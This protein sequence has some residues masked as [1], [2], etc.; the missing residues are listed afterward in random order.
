MAY[1]MSY[2]E[3]KNSKN[4]AFIVIKKIFYDE[5]LFL[6]AFCCFSVYKL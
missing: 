5:E 1:K 2:S 3:I 6:K 4:L